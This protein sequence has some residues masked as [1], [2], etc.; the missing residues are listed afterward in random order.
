MAALSRTVRV[1]TW[2]IAAPCNAS[3]TSG[4]LGVR[5]LPGLS[6]NSPAA[7]AGARMEPPPSFAP[8]IATTPA[9]TAAAAPPLDPP[10]E[11]ARSQGFRVG[12]HA[13]GSVIPL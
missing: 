11:R 6:P 2:F 12:P 3:P 4:P 13:E 8:A 1:R 10:G 7:D 5:P 9:A